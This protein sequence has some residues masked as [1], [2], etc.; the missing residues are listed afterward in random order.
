MME[1]LLTYILNAYPKGVQISRIFDD[2]VDCLI[3]GSSPSSLWLTDEVLN[4]LQDYEQAHE[5]E[6]CE[7]KVDWKPAEFPKSLP[8]FRNTTIHDSSI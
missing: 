6:C 2:L 3:Q 4:S 5:M 7:S 8:R 1:A